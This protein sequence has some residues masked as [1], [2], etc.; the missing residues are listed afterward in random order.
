MTGHTDARESAVT[1]FRRWLAAAVAASIFGNV[2]HAVLDGSA[3]SIAVA[4]VVAFL[5]PLGLLGSTHAAHKLVAAGIVGDAY[6]TA[7]RISIAT[8]VAAFVLSFHALMELAGDW[9]GIPWLIAWLVPVFV[10]LNITGSTVA[11]FALSNAA[12]AEVLEAQPAV[13]LDHAQPG[14][15]LQRAQAVDAL[16]HETVHTPTHVDAQRADLRKP[17]AISPPAARL[18]V[19]DLVARTEQ[20]E[21]DAQHIWDAHGATAERIV[22]DKI[23]RID[24]GKVAN[25]LHELAKGRTELSMIARDTGVGHPTVKKIANHITEQRQEINA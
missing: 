1:Y 4:V 23:V 2:A 3:G 19:A 6:T 12:R 9:A 18:T 22:N 5:L 24:R 10:D 13:A 15:M 21:A 20:E 14:P 17:E 16:V 8:V 25:V 11:L 7:L